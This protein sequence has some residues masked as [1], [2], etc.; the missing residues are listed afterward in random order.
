M[1]GTFGGMTMEVA[2]YVRKTASGQYRAST[3][4]P[5]PAWAEGGTQS[6]AVEFLR[7]ELEEGLRD[8]PTIVQLHIGI[9]GP[10]RPLPNDEM[11]Q[12]WLAELKR[13]REES[14]TQPDPRDQLELESP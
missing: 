13:I 6:D 2:V 14:R 7:H 1:K 10:K 3:T 4:Q 11:T 5:F 8:G 9:P 12:Q